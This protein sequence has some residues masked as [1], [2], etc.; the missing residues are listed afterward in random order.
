MS[1][2]RVSLKAILI[3]YNKIG[4][5]NTH[6]IFAKSFFYLKKNL[7]KYLDTALNLVYN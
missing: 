5:Y 7:Q 1:I 3:T 2:E 4:K 6:T